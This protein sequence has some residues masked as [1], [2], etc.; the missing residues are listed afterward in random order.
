MYPYLD[1][2]REWILIHEINSNVAIYGCILGTRGG[3]FPSLEAELCAILLTIITSLREDGYTCSLAGVVNGHIEVD[4]QGIPGNNKD[5]NSNGRLIQNCV[6]T[7]GLRILNGDAMPPPFTGIGGC[8][9]PFP[10]PLYALGK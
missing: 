5:I 7:N 9:A 1:N 2:E 8:T 10:P 4:S 3:K 6:S